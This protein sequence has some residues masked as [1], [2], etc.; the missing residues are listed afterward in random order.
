MIVVLAVRTY[1][2]WE[3]DKRVGI[4]LALLLGLYQIPYV[5]TLNKYI[6]GLGCEYRVFLHLCLR[7]FN[8]FF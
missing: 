6:Q 5:I 3:R 2:V 4:G 7:V 8:P 1:A